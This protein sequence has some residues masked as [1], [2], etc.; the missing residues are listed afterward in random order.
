MTPGGQ[1]GVIFPVCETVVTASK[2]LSPQI[3]V[4]GCILGVPGRQTECRRMWGSRRRLSLPEPLT[5]FRGQAAFTGDETT[6]VKNQ[7]TRLPFCRYSAVPRALG[8]SPSRG[9][10]RVSA[11]CMRHARLTTSV[12]PPHGTLRGLLLPAR[13]C[14][15]GQICDVESIPCSI[16]RKGGWA[17]CKPNMLD[18]FLYKA[19]QRFSPGRKKSKHQYP[20]PVSPIRKSR[21]SIRLA[22]IPK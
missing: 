22:R 13:D 14:P 6:K 8:L 17:P 11:P 5:E 19:E 3:C 20:V 18:V 9:G 15:C 7:R 21:L 16:W 10:E 2:G 4:T 1:C 12:R